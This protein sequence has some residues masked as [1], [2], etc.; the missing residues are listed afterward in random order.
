MADESDANLVLVLLD[1]RTIE[2]LQK[3][4]DELRE[5]NDKLAEKVLDLT[6]QNSELRKQLRVYQDRA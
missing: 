2:N 5:T 4:I 3:K 6:K 1:P